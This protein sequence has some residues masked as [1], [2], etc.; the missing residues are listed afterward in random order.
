MDRKKQF[1]ILGTI[2][3]LILLA[4]VLIFNRQYLAQKF[5]GLEERR[6]LVENGVLNQLS[7]WNGVLV[8]Q[9]T[10]P[11]IKF[12]KVDMLIKSISIKCEHTLSATSGR[13]LYR[14]NDQ[15]VDILNSINYTPRYNGNEIIV[16]LPKTQFVSDLAINPSDQNGD[17]IRCSDFVVNPYSQ[18]HFTLARL[19][20][21]LCLLAF[22]I[23][24]MSKAAL[25]EQKVSQQNLTSRIKK[26]AWKRGYTLYSKRVVIL[27]I[28]WALFWLLPWAEWLDALPWLRSGLSL[29]LFIT[30]GLSLSLLL[31][32]E[33]FSLPTHFVSGLALS[34][35]WVDFFGFTGRVFHWSFEDVKILFAISGLLILLLLVR[36]SV[37]HRPLYKPAGFSGKTL[38]LML[39]MIVF[40]ILANIPHEHSTDDFS[41]I[42]YLTTWQHAQR[43][44]FREVIYGIGTADSLRFWW[45]MFP[46]SLALLAEISNL[47]GLLLVSFYLEPFLII[48]V[49]LATYALSEDLL[50]SQD[51]AIIATLLQFTILFLLRQVYQPGMMLLTRPSDDKVLAAFVLAPIFFL[52]LRYLLEAF[53]WR[54]GLF[55]LLTGSSLALTHLIILAYS[56][57][58]VG[59]YAVIE[60]I[61]R[62]EYTK[63]GIV[64]ILLILILAPSASLRFIDDV[65]ITR[66]IFRM[67]PTVDLQDTFSLDA[68]REESE[69]VDTLIADV[70]GTP[71]YG[72]TLERIQ[73][74]LNGVPKNPLLILLSWSYIWVLGLGFLWSL[75]NLK[76]DTTAPIIAATSFLVLLCAIPYTG[77]LVGYFVSARM[78]WRSPWLLPIG[79]ICF[80]LVREIFRMI[81]SRISANIP[82][83]IKE[84]LYTWIPVASL[85]LVAGLH[86]FYFQHQWMSKEKLERYRN[87]LIGFAE[88]GHF[89]DDNVEQPG[90]FVARPGLMNYLPGL[91][92]KSKVVLFRIEEWTPYPIDKNEI[93]SL[94]SSD[95][96]ISLE[97]RTLILDRYNVQYILTDNPAVQEYYVRNPDA[98]SA[99]NFDGYWLIKYKE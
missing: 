83:P 34:V 11:R 99:Q 45:G 50:A 60:T 44:D 14:T 10:N 77:W 95:P 40:G 37:S 52:A 5:S 38:V 98:F 92:A 32:R 53:H 47:H 27:P 64:T 88:L 61:I 96:S 29:L 33:R 30:P 25:T 17:F 69:T 49:S 90:R 51:Q 48:V 24:E 36:Y 71:F 39:F 57:F 41:F 97:Q 13:V 54:S 86:E 63:L 7:N 89:I 65:W 79:L 75:F 78:L 73:I 62:K 19:T 43:L 87:R 6:L 9:G 80:V 68:A 1:G 15:P 8:S 2:V 21:Y 56:V 82:L 26:S 4:E 28:A 46:M 23:F 76:R 93:D 85:I 55:F 91:S 22:A 72:F 12:E 94:V 81:K 35:F 66:S 42:A 31:A 18:L 20:L 74:L 59:V 58:I 16:F 67:E 70:E 84:L 3:L